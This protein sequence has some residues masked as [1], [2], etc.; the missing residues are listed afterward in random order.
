MAA[1]LPTPKPRKQKR[2]A[3]KY[4][5][6]KGPIVGGPGRFRRPPQVVARSSSATASF[7]PV[8]QSSIPVIIARGLPMRRGTPT[9]P[10]ARALVMSRASP[11]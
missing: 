3:R 8:T 10:E 4:L 6:R 11:A 5:Q 1:E 7:I 9:R 2:G